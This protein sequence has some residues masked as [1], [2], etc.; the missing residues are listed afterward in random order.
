MEYSSSLAEGGAWQGTRVHPVDLGATP[1]C[2]QHVCHNLGERRAEE[3]TLAGAAFKRLHS[4]LHLPKFSLLHN[5]CFGTLVL[6]T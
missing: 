5:G 1:V 4:E 6:L 3:E 2:T